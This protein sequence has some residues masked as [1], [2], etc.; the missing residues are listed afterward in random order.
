MPTRAK[1]AATAKRRAPTIP[2][3]VQI[4]ESQPQVYWITPQVWRAA[5]R[6]HPELAKR[7]K[8][9]FATDK[10][11]DLAAL[12]HAEIMVSG[13]KIDR[14]LVAGN[15]KSL[16]WLHVNAAGVEALMPLNWLPV[17]AVLTNASGV[18]G[19]KA[20]EFAMMALLMLNDQM[21]LHID[22]Q[23]VRRWNQEFSGPI[24]GKTVVIVGVGA[25]GTECARRAKQFGMTVIGV[26]RSGEPASHVDRMVQ[27][28]QL[29]QVL[30]KADFVLVVAPLTAES[31]GLIGRRELELLKPSAGIVNM[32]RGPI[33]DYVALAELLRAGRLSGA[34]LDVFDP[35]PLPA[36]SPL[37]ST[38]RLLVV[39]HVSSDDRARYAARCLDVLF[40]NLRSYL[41]GRPLPNLV[42]PELGY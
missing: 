23:K 3:Y 42:R 33:V 5:A 15:A 27:P 39:P 24:A 40:D 18:H 12:A 41:R 8:P 30:P 6:R 22:D 35:E 9:S 34:I 1:S 19:P 4:I 16:K 10:K 36:G 32:G 20:G 37:W 13:P 21:P 14:G 28:R 7:L 26:R 38:P 25:I 29:P 31:R 17:G 11:P 2:V